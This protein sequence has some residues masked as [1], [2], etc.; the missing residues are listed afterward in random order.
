MLDQYG[1][2]LTADCFT[3]TENK[4]IFAAAV[5]QI[6]AGKGCDAVTLMEELRGKVGRCSKGSDRASPVRLPR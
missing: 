6:S 2:R 1:D 3:V 4:L 5:K